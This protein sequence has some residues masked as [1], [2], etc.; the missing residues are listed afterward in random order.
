MPELNQD[1]IETL[2]KQAFEQYWNFDRHT[3]WDEITP[4]ERERWTGMTRNLFSAALD[5][6]TGKNSRACFEAC[7][8][9]DGLSQLPSAHLKIQDGIFTVAQFRRS[10]TG[11]FEFPLSSA[12]TARAAIAAALEK[13]PAPNIESLAPN[14]RFETEKN[15]RAENAKA[16]EA[17]EKNRA[18]QNVCGVCAKCGVEINPRELH[19][20]T[21]KSG[22]YLCKKCLDLPSEKASAY[23]LVYLAGPYRHENE[24]GVLTNILMARAWAIKILETAAGWFPVTPHLNTAFMGGTTPDQTFLDGDLEILRRCDAIL[25]L[26]F[27]EQ[28]SGAR[29]ELFFA[30]ERHIPVYSSPEELPRIE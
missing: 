5:K 17:E 16:F 13:F 14:C 29:A 20:T 1:E 7:L 12:A 3:P 2:A 19:M 10:K 26:P 9:E 30:E 21:G 22:L 27:W 23:R 6:I 15:I 25:M 11:A 8:I 28:S 18:E 4:D 24:N